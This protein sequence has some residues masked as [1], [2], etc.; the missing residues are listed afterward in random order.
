MVARICYT[1]LILIVKFQIGKSS[2]Y[3]LRLASLL[4]ASVSDFPLIW[5]LIFSCAVASDLDGS[6]HRGSSSG[7]V[8]K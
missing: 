5:G 3:N 8:G 6:L 7:V 2:C 4:F 1:Y